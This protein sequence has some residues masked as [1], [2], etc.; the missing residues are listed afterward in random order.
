MVFSFAI[1]IFCNFKNRK[2]L[3]I[4][5]A[6]EPCG[7]Q[8][9]KSRLVRFSCLFDSTEKKETRSTCVTVWGTLG[10]Q[11]T[12]QLQK[13]LPIV[14]PLTPWNSWAGSL[15]NSYPPLRIRT[16][17]TRFVEICHATCAITIHYPLC[18]K[19]RIAS[20]RGKI[21]SHATVVFPP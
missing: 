12:R 8:I 20:V 9:N 15:Q 18:Y 19:S 3:R 11:S 7:S 1:C 5:V 4:R 2:I 10:P 13:L 16:P 6:H 17:R 14:F 21:F